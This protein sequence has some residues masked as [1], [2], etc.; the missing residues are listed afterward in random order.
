MF[1]FPSGEFSCE[2]CVDYAP[3]VSCEGKGYTTKEECV[4]CM[5]EKEVYYW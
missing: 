2:K 5:K 3:G 1:H 4:T